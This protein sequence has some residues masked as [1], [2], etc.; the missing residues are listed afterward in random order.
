MIE[1]RFDKVSDQQ[2]KIAPSISEKVSCEI[3]SSDESQ[4]KDLQDRVVN[5]D[6]EKIELEK[7]MRASEE[8]LESVLNENTKLSDNLS[9][10]QEEC[11]RIRKE[12]V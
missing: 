10:A 12:N 1:R 7:R 9:N 2:E 11:E 8:Q 5:L 6:R 4:L 3:S